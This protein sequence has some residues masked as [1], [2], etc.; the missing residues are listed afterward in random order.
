MKNKAIV[1]S[2]AVSLRNLDNQMGW[3]VIALNSKPQGSLASST[4]DPKEKGKEQGD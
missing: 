4:V 3:L 2:Q 1:Q